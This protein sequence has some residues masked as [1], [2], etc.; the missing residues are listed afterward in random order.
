MQTALNFLSDDAVKAK[1]SSAKKLSDVNVNDY[2]AVFY[3]GGHGPIMDLSQDP[4]NAQVVSNVSSAMPTPIFLT[5]THAFP[6][7]W[8]AGK[9][10]SAGCHGTAYV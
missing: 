6:Q 5:Y 10:V 3:V 9:I 1:L 2:D 4:I 8:N 7:F